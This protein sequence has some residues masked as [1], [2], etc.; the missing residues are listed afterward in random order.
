M[1]II[2]AALFTAV[3][4]GNAQCACSGK[5]AANAQKAPIKGIVTDAEAGEP[6]VGASVII[7]DTKTGTMTGTDGGFSLSVATTRLQE[8]LAKKI[9]ESADNEHPAYYL[10]SK[11]IGNWANEKAEKS[12]GCDEKI[13]WTRNSLVS[14][15]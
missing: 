2:G 1:F 8:T 5:A 7:K 9:A 12:D 4:S 10:L 13:H 15:K 6:I 14:K 11:K 3:V